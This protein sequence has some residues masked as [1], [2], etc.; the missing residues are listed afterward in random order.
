VVF[1]ALADR[2]GGSFGRAGKGEGK[3]GAGG[4]GVLVAGLPARVITRPIVAWFPRLPWRRP[5][6]WVRAAVAVTG[7]KGWVG[8]APGLGGSFWVLAAG[9]DWALSGR[10]VC[11]V[12]GYCRG[13]RERLLRRVLGSE[14]L[15]GFAMSPYADKPPTS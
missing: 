5:T 14:D 9:V 12:A 6:V 11:G 13:H 4:R 1:L 3:G 2:G 15:F 8:C 10:L 7:A